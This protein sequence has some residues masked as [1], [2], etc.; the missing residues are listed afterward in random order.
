MAVGTLARE[1]EFQ[2]IRKVCFIVNHLYFIRIPQGYEKGKLSL[3]NWKPITKGDSGGPLYFFDSGRKKAVL[4]GV[5]NRG[6]G[7]GRKDAL[8]IF[9]RV[10]SHLRWIWRVAKG[11]ACSNAKSSKNKK[12][13]SSFE[14]FFVDKGFEWIQPSFGTDLL[15]NTTRK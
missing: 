3:I 10:K 6:Q 2:L 4:V 1:V 7:C 12:K 8:S 9:A 15:N 5:T 13:M 14:N 11:G